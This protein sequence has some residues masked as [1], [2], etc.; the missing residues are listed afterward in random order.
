MNSIC[1]FDTCSMARRLMKERVGEGAVS[2]KNKFEIDLFD[3]LMMK[4]SSSI[5]ITGFLGSDLI[6]EE[7]KG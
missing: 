5:I 4:F 2:K 6:K 7:L 3:D 1:A